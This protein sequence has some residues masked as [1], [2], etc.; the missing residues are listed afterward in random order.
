[1]I[2]TVYVEEALWDHPRVMALRERLHERRWIRC[3]HY[4]E[5]FNPRPQHFRLQ[6]RRPALIVAQKQS[7]L[8]MEAPAG[9]AIGGRH[10]YY[11]SH[12]LN[13]PYDCRYCFLQ[14][15]F[16]SA[17]FV[18]FVN[19][20][21]FRQAIEETYRKHDGGAVHFFS[22][23]DSDSLALEPVTGF[24]E[25]FLEGFSGMPDNACL[26]LRSKSTNIRPLLKRDALPNVVCAFS[27]TPQIVAERW[28]AGVPPVEKRIG[29]L[30]KLQ[31]RGWPIG[32]RFDPLIHVPDWRGHYR[33]LFEQLFAS[34][35]G[36][37]IHSVSIGVFRLPR[38]YYDR[39]VD[40]HPSE[41]LFHGP[42]AREGRMVAYERA[43]EQEMVDFCRRTLLEFL[44]GE[45]L[46]S[47][48]F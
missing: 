20:E 43:L 42:L 10:N 2:E 32:L 5:V 40:L 14:G 27:F 26:E 33:R 17:H 4:G 48:Q 23:Y 15:M 25:W 35:D 8:L 9:Y 22:G 34:L 16:R 11:F 38:G 41:P 24:A 39:M 6:K 7:R 18:W 44:P 1:M 46:F 30:Q 19:Y 13:C 47:C 37:A 29:A 21:D 3:R 28:E 45:K 31:E 12:L 36:E